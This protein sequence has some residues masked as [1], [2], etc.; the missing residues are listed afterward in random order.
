MAAAG[1]HKTVEA[2]VPTVTNANN[3]SICC[4]V[5]PREHG[6][7]G[8]YYFNEASGEHDYMEV[9]DFI[10]VPTL[11][12]RAAHRRTSALLTCKKKTIP[13]GEGASIAIAAEAPQRNNERLRRS[14]TSTAAINY[15]LWHGDRHPRRPPEIGVVC[16]PPLPDAHVGPRRESIEHM[17]TLDRLHGG[18]PRPRRRGVHHRRSRHELPRAAGI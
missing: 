17:E 7:T 13:A 1:L 11:L 12:Q 9:A 14:V 4:G 3:V 16:T 2:V 18:G 15:W 10:R 6:I 8:N 5:M